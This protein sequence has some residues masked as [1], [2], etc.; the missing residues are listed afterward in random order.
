MSKNN[1]NVEWERIGV[2]GSIEKAS[3]TLSQ[4]IEM[5]IL[6]ELNK[7]KWEEVTL[8]INFNTNKLKNTFVL[9]MKS[10]ALLHSS[11]YHL[12]DKKPIS[13][14]ITINFW[15]VQALYFEEKDLILNLRWMPAY[16]VCEM[17]LI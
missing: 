17:I 5:E 7:C 3:F 13:F 8:Q 6:Y 2:D 12:K 15:I 16:Q 1:A 14:R 10:E 9:T 4:T 11:H